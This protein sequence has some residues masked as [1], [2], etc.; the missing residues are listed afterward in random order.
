MAGFPRS[1][2]ADVTENIMRFAVG[3]PRDR[4]RTIA[5]A[6][7]RRE[8]HMKKSPRAMVI[9]TVNTDQ[10]TEKLADPCTW[11]RR[12]PH[13]LNFAIGFDTSPPKQ[14]RDQLDGPT[15]GYNY[16]EEGRTHV[17]WHV[18]FTCETCGMN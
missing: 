12:G 17:L 13:K 10:L 2:S 5:S 14:L 11:S 16:I 3:Y 1:F 9:W 8:K 15:S 18:Y 4:L 7:E 6:I